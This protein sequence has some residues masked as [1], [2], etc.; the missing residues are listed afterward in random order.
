MS[1]VTDEKQAIPTGSGRDIQ[2]AD[3]VNEWSKELG[4]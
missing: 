1:T 3:V 4:D 2:K